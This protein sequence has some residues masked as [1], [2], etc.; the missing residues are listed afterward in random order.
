[1][2]RLPYWAGLYFICQGAIILAMFP[3]V[4]ESHTLNKDTYGLL[5]KAILFTL[6]LSGSWSCPLFRISIATHGFAYGEK[7]YSNWAWW[8]LA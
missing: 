1:M 7:V 3:M 2:Q 4:S 8:I 6:L 5:N